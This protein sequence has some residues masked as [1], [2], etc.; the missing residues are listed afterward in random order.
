MST[1]E[2]RD[3]DMSAWQQIYPLGGR[4]LPE[5]IA[6]KGKTLIGEIGRRGWKIL[7]IPRLM[8]DEAELCN[9]RTLGVTSMRFITYWNVHEWLLVPPEDSPLRAR[10]VT[11]GKITA[12]RAAWRLAMFGEDAAQPGGEG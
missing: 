8:S 10:R 11:G 5:P 6:G 2:D 3:L 12:I 1:Q 9:S 7:P 4:D